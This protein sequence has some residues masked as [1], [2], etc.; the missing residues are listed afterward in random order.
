M[1]CTNLTSVDMSKISFDMKDTYNL[2]S[3]FKNCINLKSI[4]LK[5]Y[6]FKVG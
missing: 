6:K 5:I 1:S 4:N 2:N 3:M